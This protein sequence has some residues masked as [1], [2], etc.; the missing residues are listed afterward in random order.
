MTILAL[1][2]RVPI[3]LDSRLDPIS[4]LDPLLC[5]IIVL[6][7]TQSLEQRTINNLQV[8]IIRRTQ[9]VQQTQTIEMGLVWRRSHH[10]VYA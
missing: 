1:L 5:V 2:C 10:S 3:P 7:E 6:L 9:E 4:R 8:Q